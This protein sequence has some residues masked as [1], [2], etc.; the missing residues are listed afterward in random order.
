VRNG[1]LMSYGPAEP[2]NIASAAIYVD[3]ILKGA[4]V[5]ELPFEEPA[6]IKLVINLRTARAIGLAFS[7]TLLARADEVIE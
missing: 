3:R 2:E 5:A 1:A 7:P 4:K 6:E